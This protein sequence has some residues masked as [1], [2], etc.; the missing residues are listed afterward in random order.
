VGAHGVAG[1]V[2]AV[3]GAPSGCDRNE[4]RAAR[5][6]AA[7]DVPT[8]REPAHH[9][10]YTRITKAQVA[11]PQTLAAYDAVTAWAERAGRG[12][13]DPSREVYF[14][15]F[16]TAAPTDTVCDIALPVRDREY[17]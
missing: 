17:A 8:R 16:G 9:E 12:V 15:D 10:A 7:A 3:S 2:Y 11:Y 13:A 6:W 14:A 4:E 5:S 1:S